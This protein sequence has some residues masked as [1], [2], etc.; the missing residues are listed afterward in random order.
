[1]AADDDA[2]GSLPLI[3]PMLAIEGQLPPAPADEAYGVET[4]WDGARVI[5]YAVGDG[6]LRLLSRSGDDVTAAFPE[7]HPLGEQLGRR[8][9]VLD[10]EIVALDDGGRP[11]FGRLQR[12]TGVVD[13]R[14]VARLAIDVPVHLMLF[15]VPY[16]DGLP[17]WSTPYRERRML[18]EGMDLAG[19]RW[20]TPSYA[21]GHAH[22]AWAAALAYGH[23]G[24]VCK[25]L[26]SEYS[27]GRR[28]ADWIKVVRTETLD[29]VIGGW[30]EGR[31]DLRGLPGAVLVGIDAP[32]GLRYVGGVG[33]GLSDAER[34]E[35]GEYLG[36]LAAEESPFVNPV[37]DEPDVRW[38]RPRLVVEVTA[39][40][41]TFGGRLRHPTWRRLRPDR[42]RPA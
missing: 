15:D 33:S 8:Q 24:V 10:G 6:S 9:V 23:E 28:S 11:D 19:P 39:S 40:G 34:G 35:L 32:G 30:V 26:D 18:L 29:V 38:V 25:R 5:S 22:E 42:T 17:R 31:G 16:V 21:E 13:P 2:P 41:R 12:R 3:E 37:D 14:K 7:L 27:P 36:A 4:K 20:T 1:M